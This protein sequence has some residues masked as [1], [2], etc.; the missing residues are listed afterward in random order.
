M[1]QEQENELFKDLGD[2]K[3]TQ[4]AILERLTN[5]KADATKQTDAL[6]TR[7]LTL[8]NKLTNMQ[9]KLAG[10][11]SVGGVIAIVIGELLKGVNR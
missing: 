7:I 8:E 1:N 2:I 11:G 5:Y 9:I 6:D 10:A 4:R 3:A